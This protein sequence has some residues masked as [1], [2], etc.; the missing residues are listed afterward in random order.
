MLLKI[1]RFIDGFKNC[2]GFIG[3]GIRIKIFHLRMTKK[4]VIFLSWCMVG[5]WKNKTE[6]PSSPYQ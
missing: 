1:G 4:M 3:G 6:N 2:L 5:G